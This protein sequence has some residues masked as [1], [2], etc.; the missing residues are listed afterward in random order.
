MHKLQIL[1]NAIDE[2]KEPKLDLA[3][4]VIDEMMP[5]AYIGVGAE[6]CGSLHVPGEV[7]IN[8]TFEGNLNASLLTIG[9]TGLV[10]GYIEADNVH[11]YGKSVQ[12]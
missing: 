3:V 5:L 4:P 10:R 9:E 1:S 2:K 11:I 7:V 12:T 8:G 6:L